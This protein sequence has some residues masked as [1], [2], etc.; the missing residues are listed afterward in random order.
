MADQISAI[1]AIG[2]VAGSRAIDLFAQARQRSVGDGQANLAGRASG[3]RKGAPADVVE[4]SV[5][6][7]TVRQL[8]ANVHLKFMRDPGSSRFIVQVIDSTT[9][10][11][12][13]V[14]PPSKLR[15]TLLHLG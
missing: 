15:E 9:D 8:P 1:S 14:V 4:L 6:P 2:E 10:E 3:L 7:E 12:I 5:D 11:V 13:R